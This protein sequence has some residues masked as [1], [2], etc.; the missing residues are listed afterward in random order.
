MTKKK[1]ETA[2][3]RAPG[4][5]SAKR[6][7]AGKMAHE[8]RM[9]IPLVRL[10][11]MREGRGWSKAKAADASGMDP[12]TYSRIERCVVC[13]FPDQADAIAGA[14]GTTVDDLTEGFPGKSQDAA[15]RD[16]GA[17]GTIEPAAGDG[18]GMSL[19]DRVLKLEERLWLLGRAVDMLRDAQEPLGR[20]VEEL[21]ARDAEPVVLDRNGLPMRH[22]SWFVFADEPVPAKAAPHWIESVELHEVEGKGLLAYFPD[23]QGRYPVASVVGGRCPSLA[24]VDI[25][26]RGAK[27]AV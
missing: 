14:F 25:V 13:P 27:G 23:G 21:E 9:T 6:S 19:A 15:A 4:K 1:P 7:A 10:A 2:E 18:A 3:K 20:A 24:L 17:D 12:T 22:G 8:S 11:A 5:L 16:A 26:E